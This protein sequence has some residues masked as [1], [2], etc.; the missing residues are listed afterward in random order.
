[1]DESYDEIMKFMRELIFSDSP[2]DIREE[3][4]DLLLKEAGATVE[5]AKGIYVL[6]PQYACML[7]SLRSKEKIRAIKQLRVVTGLSLKDAKEIVEDIQKR[8]IDAIT[9]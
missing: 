3:A 6:K 7:A 4:L 5:V 9:T 1:M 8:E 2:R